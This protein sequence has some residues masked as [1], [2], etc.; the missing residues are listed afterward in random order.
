M[1]QPKLTTEEQHKA[2]AEVIGETKTMAE[3]ARKY[4]VST[5]RIRQLLNLHYS[6]YQIECWRN[7]RRK[8]S[9]EKKRQRIL[10]RYRNDEGFRRKSIERSKAYSKKKRETD[11][12]FVAR[13]RARNKAYTDRHKKKAWFKKKNR[14]KMTNY[15]HAVLR[16]MIPHEKRRILRSAYSRKK[17]IA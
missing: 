2:T 7:R 5:E 15:Y 17:Y 4:G 13:C 3:V 8:I 6:Q 1:P 12:D 16:A 9:K 14:E 11:P 10:F